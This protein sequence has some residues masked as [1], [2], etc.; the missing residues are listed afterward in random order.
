MNSSS[1]SSSSFE[2]T[3]L[4]RLTNGTEEGGSSPPS[5]FNILVYTGYASTLVFGVLGNL[6]V[7]YVLLC[8]MGIERRNLDA[9]PES[10]LMAG[11][12]RAAARD[13]PTELFT[14][15]QRSFMR[16]RGAMARIRKLYYERLSIT[17]LYLVNL[18]VS[19]LLYVLL[20][21]IL[22]TTMNVNKWVFGPLVCKLFFTLSYL[23]Q[24]SSV[25]ILVVLSVDR[26]LSI[27]YPT[28]LNKFRSHGKA[29]M[30]IALTWLLSALFT[31][32]VSVYTRQDRT[33]CHISWP[34]TV[35]TLQLF[36][37]YSSLFCYFVPVAIIIV[38]YTKIL[39]RLRELNQN[40][41]LSS[42]SERRRK[43]HRK[44]TKM[45]LMIIICYLVCWS[46]YWLTQ[47][48]FLV[49][50]ML[51]REF[52]QLLLILAHLSQMVAYMNSALNPFIYSYMSEAFKTDFKLVI[53][54][55]DC[56]K[57]C[58]STACCRAIKSSNSSSANE[59]DEQFV[60]A[61]NV[62]DADSALNNARPQLEPRSALNESTSLPF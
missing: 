2:N 51:G 61:P 21:P 39:L 33:A 36:S 11:T 25:F 47:I 28:Q 1:S 24:F 44:I 5:V 10:R 13:A 54:S 8:S 48:F 19:D 3:S 22:I 50:H 31:L 29:R 34:E 59:L 35:E 62:L 6:M 53:N 16:Q 26:Y 12:S 57:K 52:S 56:G 60:T 4:A 20:I 38:L 23:C 18:A 42:V 30:V 15:T 40:S 14:A 37:V 55:T 41:R 9:P 7:I 17:N 58:V 43:S 45:V 49:Y 32:P 46:P 27:K